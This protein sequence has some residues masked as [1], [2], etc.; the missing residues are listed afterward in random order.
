MKFDEIPEQLKRNINMRSGEKLLIK[1]RND[2]RYPKTF[3]GFDKTQILALKE[4]SNE[5]II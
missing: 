2:E 5:D 4:D 1:N 3:L